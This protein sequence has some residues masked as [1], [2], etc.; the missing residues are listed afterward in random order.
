MIKS[1]KHM[2]LKKK[3]EQSVNILILP[4][5]WSKIHMEVTVTKFR[6]E[7]DR[8][9]IQRLPQLEI[10]PRNNHQKQTLLQMPTRAC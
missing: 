3:E 9:T 5:T 1:A 7:T 10:H 8:M 2:K 6:V 4:R